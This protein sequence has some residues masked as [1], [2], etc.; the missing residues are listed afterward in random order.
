MEVNDMADS[1][2]RRASTI[3]GIDLRSH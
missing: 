2:Y 3:T 1:V